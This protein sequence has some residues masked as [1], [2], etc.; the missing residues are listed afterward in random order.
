[1]QGLNRYRLRPD[2]SRVLC[3]EFR[4]LLTDIDFRRSAPADVDPASGVYFWV[5]R[6][7]SDVYKIYIGRTR[8]IAKRVRDYHAEFQVHSP[9]DFKLRFFQEFVHGHFPDATFDLYFRAEPLETCKRIETE[10]IRRY[11]P[12]MNQRS[13]HHEARVALKASFAEYYS[14]VFGLRL[15][16]AEEP[17]QGVQ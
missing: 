17:N 12:M 14:Q 5:L 7:S 11:D 2:E 16:Q 8:S 9:N 6:Q 1:M 13:R 4:A 3:A 10:C 15:T